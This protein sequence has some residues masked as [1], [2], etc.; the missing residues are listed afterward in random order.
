[1]NEALITSLLRGAYA[2]AVITC[3]ASTIVVLI[4][5]GC[6]L[7]TPVDATAGRSARD[8]AR[9]TR[10]YAMIT[11]LSLPLPWSI[12]WWFVIDMLHLLAW[13]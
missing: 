12:F 9:R 13:R 11:L 3:V 6:G 10:I 5:V 7:T 8:A 2:G 1:M 4:V